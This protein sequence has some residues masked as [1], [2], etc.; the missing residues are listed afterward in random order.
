[1]SPKPITHFIKFFIFVFITTTLTAQN[2]KFIIDTIYSD[3]IFSGL[4]DVNKSIL[5][6]GNGQESIIFRDGK[7]KLYSKDRFNWHTHWGDPQLIEFNGKCYKQNIDFSIDNEKYVNLSIGSLLRRIPLM[8]S[9]DYI[10][11]LK[12]DSMFV[13]NFITHKSTFVMLAEYLLYPN[14]NYITVGDLYSEERFIYVFESKNLIKIPAHFQFTETNHPHFFSHDSFV[15]T[16]TVRNL[17]LQEVVTRSEGF[18]EFT[19]L[20]DIFAVYGNG[21][22]SKM[23]YKGES[24]EFEDNYIEIDCR[25]SQ[26]VC[27]L[28]NTN[29]KVS[30]INSKGQFI[31][32]YVF[33]KVIFNKFFQN[34]IILVKDGVMKMYDN[35]FKFIFE[36][37]YDDMELICK[38]RLIV[39]KGHISTLV[40]LKG[41]PIILN[42]NFTNYHVS[43]FDKFGPIVINSSR[44]NKESYYDI[45]GNE[46]RSWKF[47]N[48]KSN[49]EIVMGLRWPFIKSLTNEQEEKIN[50]SKIW[51]RISKSGAKQFYY[52]CDRRGIRLTHNY[53]GI[54]KL[55]LEGN[56]LVT[57]F[58]NKKGVINIQN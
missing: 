12:G 13:A 1:M 28:T 32:P 5:L 48:N 43:S 52:A 8:V 33:D 22:T 50:P 35:E 25:E 3:V 18:T 57:T 39:R 38:N 31:F 56:Y 20:G 44:D 54:T 34:E 30:I 23:F 9:E 7:T 47:E 42:T 4:F 37:E 24:L 29:N 17:D 40:N 15:D 27:F 36:G 51:I 49:R 10:T 16:I 6:S 58:N 26:N 14:K 19:E 45:D 21:K 53:K 55:G 11:Y 41:E 2:E 46:I